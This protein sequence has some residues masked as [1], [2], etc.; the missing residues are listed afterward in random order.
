MLWAGLLS[1]HAGGAGEV[2]GG[3]PGLDGLTWRRGKGRRVFL[4][5]PPYCQ[6]L[7]IASTR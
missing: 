5:V 6:L 2:G 1:H 7:Y 4:L 3:F